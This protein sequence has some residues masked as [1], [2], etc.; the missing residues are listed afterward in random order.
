MEIRAVGPEEAMAVAR[1]HLQADEETYRPIF[2]ARFQV[3]SL[4]AF[5]ERWQ[6]AL[7]S[8]DVFLAAVEGGAIVGFTHAHADW[9]SALYLLAGHK[10]HGTGQKLLRALCEAVRALGV[11]EIRFDCIAE[12]ASAIAFYGAMGARQVGRKRE[13]QGDHAWEELLFALPTDSLALRR[14]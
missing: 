13:A 9:M 8:G 2:G 14:A 4:D 11:T 5:R 6:A 1:V 7:A 10:R 3:Q 12:N